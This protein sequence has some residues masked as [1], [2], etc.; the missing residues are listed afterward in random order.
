MSWNAQVGD[1]KSI[2]SLLDLG[3]RANAALFVTVAS[4]C[5]SPGDGTELLPLPLGDSV[6]AQERRT[7]QPD[8]PCL[9]RDLC[10]RF[11]PVPLPALNLLCSAEPPAKARAAV[12]L[13]GKGREGSVLLVS[14]SLIQALTANQHVS[15]TAG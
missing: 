11:E 7:L 4:L 1:R 10:I 12:E 9:S 5:I 6:R 8:G 3:P 2:T 15:G 13:R 14:A